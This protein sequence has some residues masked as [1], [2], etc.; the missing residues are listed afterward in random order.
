MAIAERRRFKALAERRRSLRIAPPEGRGQG[1]RASA[2]HHSS[3]IKDDSESRGMGDHGSKGGAGGHGRG[4]E[5]GEE[6]EGHR[7]G[8]T[9][10]KS[11]T[12][13]DSE[14]R[15]IGAGDGRPS[16]EAGMGGRNG[17]EVY[18]GC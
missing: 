9:F 5:T 1:P 12:K 2:T 3:Q 18:S 4:P 11:Q 14:S 17:G 10:H 15:G 16:T 13:D 6:H 7:P 8:A